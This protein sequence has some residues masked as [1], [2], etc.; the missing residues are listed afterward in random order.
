MKELE[1]RAAAPD[2]W[3][4]PRSAQKLQVD[5]ARRR[6]E[7]E[8]LQEL[9]ARAED[10]VTLGELAEE[11]GSQEEAP[12]IEEGL[13]KLEHM[14]AEQ[15]LSRLFAGEYD[16]HNAIVHINA[17]AGGT[18]ACDWVDM[19]ARMYGRWSERHGYGWEI[20]D[21]TPGEQAGTRSITAS[22]TGDHAYGR[23]RGER[24]VHRLVRLSP[25][26]AANRRHTTFASVDVMPEVEEADDVAINLDD[27]KIETYRASSAGG[28]HVNKTD[29]AVR[30]THVPTGI[31]VTCQNERSQHKNRASA[32]RVLK[33]RLL[34]LQRQE[35][36]KKLAELRGELT[37]IAWGHQ[38]RSYVLHPYQMVKDHRTGHE[39]GSAWAVLEGEL[40]GFLQAYLRYDMEQRAKSGAQ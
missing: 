28:Q 19:L 37:E 16:S 22:I 27:L 2:L 32:L 12:E 35:Q 36:E 1:E 20:F 9:I 21:R 33:A 29:S 24:G 39:T 11:A 26:D 40:D 34:D 3:Q 30:M 10:L 17:G 23:L 13:A 38:I 6:R 25:F 7:L 8:P 31:V 14:L 18:E 4:D 15:E 5:I